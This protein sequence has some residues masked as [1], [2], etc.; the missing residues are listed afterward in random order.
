LAG[1]A[2]SCLYQGT[3]G[4]NPAGFT[5]TLAPGVAVTQTIVAD[6]ESTDS[7]AD[8]NDTAE[9]SQA[10]I[11][12]IDAGLKAVSA[13][14]E[15]GFSAPFTLIVKMADVLFGLSTNCNNQPNVFQL[16]AATADGQGTNNT[17][18]AVFD[19]CSGTCG[20][21]ANVYSS[22]WESSAP[23]SDAQMSTEAV[24]L[25]PSTVMYDGQPLWLDQQPVGTGCGVGN[26]SDSNT[27]G[28][29]SENMISL[30]WLTSPPC[31][32][33]NGLEAGDGTG[34]QGNVSWCYQDPPASPS[35][36]SCGT[37]NASCLAY[38]PDS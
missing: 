20:G 13:V 4:S 28:C 6:D 16:G 38:E 22:P 2:V 23:D 14:T 29:T 17:S 3:D 8:A 10:V 27:S 21:L 26:G 7:P 12:S 18:W 25:A 34:V 37:D 1:E 19:G 9:V 15:A 35:I 36:P 30:R 24:Q 32:W 5:T 33:T 11:E 31:P